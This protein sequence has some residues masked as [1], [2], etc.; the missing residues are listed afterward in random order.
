MKTYIISVFCFFIAVLTQ[1]Q[2]GLSVTEN[3]LYTK[4]CL[5]SAC[6]K[7]S[8]AVSY[9]DGAGK[10]RQTI[11]IA[12]SPLGKDLVQPSVYDAFG[13]KTRDYLPIPQS[14]SS[15]GA[16]Y[17][18]SSALVAY[19]VNDATNFYSGEKIFTEK[20]I[21]SS[22]LNRI[23]QQLQTGNEW[24]NKPAVL[25]YFSNLSTDQVRYFKTTSA[26]TDGVSK[27]TL[28][29]AGLYGASQLYKNSIK[30]EDGNEKLIFKNTKGQVILERKGS[31]GN[32]ADTYFV[33]DKYDHLVLVLPPLAAI[34]P[35]IIS[36]ETKRDNLCYQNRY[37]GKN[38]IA[39][40]KL[41]GK[42]WEYMVYDKQ[43]RPVAMQDAVLKTKGQW[44]YIKYDSF[45]R[46]AITGIST[47]GERS[48]E[49]AIVDGLGLNN[50]NRSNSAVF[51]RQGMSVFYG[52]Q[53]STYPN[54]TKWV[55]LLSLSYYDN[56]PQYSLNPPFPSS[57]LG[58]PVI[59]DTQSVSTQGS[60]TLTLVKNIE[61]DNWT[62]N[63]VYY[64]SKTRAVG[65]YSI[66]HLGGYTKNEV[67]L[68]FADAP[69]KFYTYHVRKP[70]EIPVEINE[71][72]VYDNQNRL[73]RHYHQ[74]GVN[75]EELLS[76]NTYNEISQLVNK[77]VGFNIQSIDYSYNIRGWLTG[78][79]ADQMA[80][81]NL[82]G[83]LFSYKI[84]YNQKDGITNADPS[85]FSGKDVKPRY[86]GNISE[87]DW[88]AVE[89]IGVNPLLTP[90]RYG[91]AYDD[92]NRQRKYRIVRL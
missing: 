34:A 80:V 6:L 15:N 43:N 5:D 42:G 68:N 89:T 21:E 12:G 59:N 74:V 79:N 47:G 46:V 92:M 78:I 69:L 83:K 50:V 14:A 86:N 85:L 31:P 16:L 18:Q 54:S 40:R 82:N 8:E 70:G 44:Q 75:P 66:N 17:Q 1:A 84:K 60:P 32:Y 65:T 67:L 64:D 91:Y 62:K 3:Y 73:K 9:F 2:T 87:V 27:T 20:T 51:E 30:D 45:G 53:D 77:K 29:D 13:K 71:R 41:P 39:E 24:N 88:R 61:N 11:D 76:D 4:N 19:P 63:Y 52:N 26:W 55:T 56:Y 23:Q 72:F 58:Q 35:D 25:G 57:I 7:R 49:Q 37:D 10:L 28:I 33:Y 22:P 90:K 48:S 38:R 81:P 36:N